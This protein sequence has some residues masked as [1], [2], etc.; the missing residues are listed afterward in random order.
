M[1][2]DSCE[3]SRTHRSPATASRQIWT[4]ALL[5]ISVLAVLISMPACSGKRPIP[6]EETGK[7]NTLPREQVLYKEASSLFDKIVRCF[8][9]SE[10]MASLYEVFTWKSRTKLQAIGVRSAQNFADWF[11]TQRQS[12]KNPFSYSF[13]RVD[14][15]DIDIHDTSRAIV[16]ASIVVSFEQQQFESVSSFF[17]SRERGMWKLPFADCDDFETCW[18]QKDKRFNLKPRDEGFTNYHSATLGI[19]LSYPLS[20]DISEN[21]RFSVPALGVVSGVLLR[22]TDPVSEIAQTTFR[23]TIAPRTALHPFPAID[24]TINRQFFLLQK[25]RAFLKDQQEFSGN[26]YWIYDRKNDR[27]LYVFGGV[28]T[29][30]PSQ[31]NFSDIINSVIESMIQIQK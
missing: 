26:E 24:T 3:H 27:L 28:N 22:Y 4:V 2:S 15:L 11:E 29:T 8:N 1:V 18:W 25:E 17:F 23:C 20:W 14:I 31:D 21:A 9:R 6:A 12:G 10:S 7:P 5:G 13:L 16:T 19:D 30:G